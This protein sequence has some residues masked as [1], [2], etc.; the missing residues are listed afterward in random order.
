MDLLSLSAGYVGRFLLYVSLSGLAFATIAFIISWIA[1]RWGWLNLTTDGPK[2]FRRVVIVVVVFLAA[3]I[4]MITGFQNGIIT[5][6]MQMLDDSGAALVTKGL[7]KA[8][9]VLGF[10]EINQEIDI[11]QAQQLISQVEEVKLIDSPGIEA[12]IVNGVFDRVRT[13]FAQAAQGA[14][15]QYAPG[16]KLIPANLASLIWDDVYGNLASMNSGVVRA[17]NIEGF[18]WLFGLCTFFM[19]GLFICR[20]AVCAG[21]KTAEKIKSKIDS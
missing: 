9:D 17:K 2:L 1:G 6:G 5:I 19:V 16:S 20:K 21:R 15:N 18:I 14:L 12:S 13:P 10:A 8:S 11:A 3:G 7:Q 4:G